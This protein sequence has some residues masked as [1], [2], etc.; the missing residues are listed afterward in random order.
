MLSTGSFVK[1]EDVIDQLDRIVG[2]SIADFGCGSGFFSLAFARV[3]GSSGK[4]YALDILA[5]SLESVSSRA[6]ASGFSNVITKRVNLERPGGSGLPDENIDW[7]IMK[8]ILFQNKNKDAMIQEAHR[9]LKVGGFLFVMEWSDADVSFGPEHHLRISRDH[10]IEM[11]SH[12]NFVPVKDV[13]VGDF[14]YGLVCQ[15]C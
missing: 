15:K 4:V 1:P 5:S 8:D 14:H 3:A 13:A 6:K 2:A 12:Y 7:V 11:L 10:L 9:I